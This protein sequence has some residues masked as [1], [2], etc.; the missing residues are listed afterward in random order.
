LLE[1][2]MRWGRRRRRRRRIII[3]IIFKN[4]GGLKRS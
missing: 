4:M 2:I 1:E 3:I